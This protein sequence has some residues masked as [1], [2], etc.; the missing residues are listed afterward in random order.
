MSQDVT[1]GTT[2][3]DEVP[4][5]PDPTGAEVLQAYFAGQ[6]K[7]LDD[8]RE[9][10]I[11][12]APDAVH[13]SRVATRRLRSLLRTF[14]PLLDADETEA[15]RAELKWW[16]DV[17]GAPRDAEVMKAKLVAAVEQLPAEKRRGPVVNR[18]T[19]E[20]DEEHR[21]SHARLV[22]EIDAPRAVALMERLHAA[23]ADFPTAPAADA[24]AGE[25]LTPLVAKVCRRV[26]AD[27]HRAM[28]EKGNASLFW[29]HETRKKAKAAR[30]AGEALV[31]AFGDDAKKLGKA[32]E[33]VTESLGELQDSAVAVEKLIELA[34]RADAAGES[35]V[36][37]WHLIDAEREIGHGAKDAGQAALE[38]VEASGVRDWTR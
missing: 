30:Y 6:V 2:T 27:A 35:T 29:W 18:I 33:A 31:D 37:Y 13:K 28:T 32:Y 16:A 38:R 3:P 36:T 15:L 14:R 7:V 1:P 8:W 24:P 20:L 5:T 23:A 22:A 26:D 21:S 12:D 17:L 19:T 4:A 10:V 9:P 11:A 34:Q 25:C